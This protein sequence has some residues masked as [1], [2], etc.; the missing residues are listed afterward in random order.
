MSPFNVQEVQKKMSDI[1]RDDPSMI[2][3]FRSK[4]V[5]DDMWEYAIIQDPTL[6]KECKTKS[7]RVCVAAVTVDGFNL[8]YIDPVDF[9]GSQYKKLCN[10]AVRQNPKCIVLVPKGF[11]TDELL[12]Y[13][14]AQD[15]ELI[16]SEKKLTDSMVMSIIDHNPSLIQY[17]AN[18]TDD[19]IIHALQKDPRTIVYFPIISDKVRQ[20]YEENYPQYAAMVLHD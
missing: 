17:V 16:L 8:E 10:V 6:F 20:F 15:P 18:P 2:L 1:I 9:N 5:T 3:T 13:A 4:Y 19:M 11:R 14:Y 12:A 7:Y